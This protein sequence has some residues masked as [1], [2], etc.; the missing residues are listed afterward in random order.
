MDTRLQL[1]LEE[2]RRL[3]KAEKLTLVLEGIGDGKGARDGLRVAR[4]KVILAG[5]ASP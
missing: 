1:C 5:H 3:A 4:A 2:L